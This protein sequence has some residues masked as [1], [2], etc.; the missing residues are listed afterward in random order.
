MA[1]L[2]SLTV[3]FSDLPKIDGVFLNDIT[4]EAYREYDMVGRDKPYRIENPVGM[5]VRNG[6]T[7]HRVVDSEGVAHCIPFGGTSG[8]VLRCKNKPGVPPVQ[9]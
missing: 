3:K 6:G 9:S 2:N 8:T 5:Y 4:A 1:N 7:T